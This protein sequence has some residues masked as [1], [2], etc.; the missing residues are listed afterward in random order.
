M[1]HDKDVTSCGLPRMNPPIVGFWGKSQ[2]DPRERID[3]WH[4]LADHC[5]DVAIVFRQVVD[6]PGFRRALEATAGQALWDEQFDRLAVFALY[7]DFGK[8]NAGFQGRLQPGA[9]RPWGHVIEAAGLFGLGETGMDALGIAE[10]S[11]WFVGGIESAQ[12]LLLAAI[13]H[14]GEPLSFNRIERENACECFAPLWKTNGQAD[15]VQGVRDLG[16]LARRAFPGAFGAAPPIDARPALQHRFAGLLMLADWIAS[17]VRHFPFRESAAEDR[18]AVAPDLSRAALAAI[19]LHS[20]LARADLASRKSAFAEVFGRPPYPFQQLLAEHLPVDEA[21]RL[22]IAESDTGSGKTEAALAWFLRLFQSGR[23]DGLYFALPTR[24]AAR[25]L[26]GRVRKAIHAAFPDETCRPGPVLLAV[27]GYARTDGDP[28]LLAHTAGNLWPDDDRDTLHDRAWVAENPKRFLAAP[29]AVG[30]VDQALLSVLQVRHAHLRSVCLDRHLLVVDEVHASD[31]YMREILRALLAHHLGVGGCALLLSA[32][33]GEAARAQFLGA[34]PRP[35]AQARAVPYPAIT[36]RTA[37]MATPRNETR[38]R[39]VRVDFL[40]ALEDFPAVVDLLCCALRAGARVLVVMNTVA[41]AVA[42]MREVEASGNI[43]PQ[44]LFEVG[45]VRC[46]H[47]GRYA[48]ADREV[49]DAAVSARFGPSSPPGPVLLVGTQTLEQ[50]LD[51]DAD[52]L[53]TDHCPM[54][55]LLQRIGRLHRHRRTA[56]PDGYENARCIVLS[57]DG[58]GL[59]RFVSPK[60]QH[61]GQGSGPAGIGTVY[62]DL[63]VL[64]LT[65]DELTATPQISIPRDNRRLVE[66]ATHPDALARLGDD[67]WAAHEQY[68][69]AKVIAECRQAEIAVIEEQAFGEFH[70]QELGGRIATRLGLNDRQ[71]KLP[72]PVATPFGQTIREVAIPGHLAPGGDV[73]DATDLR[74][75]GDGFRFALGDKRYRYSRFGLEPITDE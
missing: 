9:K 52:L 30:T 66:A 10:L 15:P 69:T 32:T 43:S 71:A 46:P 27:P 5:L 13:S 67:L 74:E 68:L 72:R 21:S 26:Y 61:R 34:E 42:L 8:F 65:R 37:T 1:Y 50:S 60:G 49:L 3:A 28:A 75:D 40:E 45:G 57:P 31:P 39:S 14:H 48:R 17:D 56:R 62:D 64:Q 47:H 38:E 12:A 4:P 33:L 16:D 54:D 63:R 25:E 59:Q 36:T 22:V 11:T 29:V 53:V 44:W 2:R 58:N 73:V 19:G 51:I 20:P 70:F 18:L 24:V 41:R 7:H 6:L 55:V 35:L 23:V